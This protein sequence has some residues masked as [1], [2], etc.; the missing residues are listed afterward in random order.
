MTL[1]WADL[2]AI[3]TAISL[4]FAIIYWAARGRLGQ[5]FVS[6]SSH[7]EAL[8]RIDAIERKL[9]MV[10]THQ[11]FQAVAAKFAIVSEEVAVVKERVEGVRESLSRI[12]RQL[13]LFV[14]AQLE[15]EAAR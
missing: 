15:R 14:Q 8:E 1:A 7:D 13:S 10:P 6:Q 3:A 11:D 9:Q 12:E 5:E 4:A 2:G